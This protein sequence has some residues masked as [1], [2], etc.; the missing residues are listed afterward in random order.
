MF[1]LFGRSGAALVSVFVMVSSFS[2]LNGSMLVAPRVFYAMAN[3]GLFFTAMARIHGKYR[4]PY[5]AIVF[6][7]LLGM[8]LVVSQSFERLTSTFVL[9]IW[10]FY[11]L[12]VAAV[13]RLRRKRPDLLR[14]YRVAGYPVVPAIFI[15]SVVWFVIN[16]LVNDAVPTIVT[17]AFILMGV[18]I[19][20]CFF[21]RSVSV[22]L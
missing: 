14:P 2:S 12:S 10:P 8:A 16:A 19:Y 13:Y 6:S 3:D 1:T 18:P 7:A 17:F 15:V 22:F 21:R 9:A 11:A 4:T 5:V 20:F